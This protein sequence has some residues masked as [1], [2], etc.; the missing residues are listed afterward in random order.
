LLASTVAAVRL[1]PRTPA[2]RALLFTG[3]ALAPALQILPLPRFS[4]PHYAHLAT[5]GAGLLLALAVRRAQ[6][7]GPSVRST[8][9]GLAAAWI[10][11]AGLVTL[12]GGPRFHD[13]V[14]LFGPELAA[15][16]DF[17]E[18][19]MQLGLHFMLKGDH[20]RAAAAFEECLRPRPGL[21][22]FRDDQLILVNLANVR[23]AQG[24]A[25]EAER[26]LAEAARQARPSDAASIAGNRAFLAAQRGDDAA[27]VELLRP[28]VGT[29]TRPEPLMLLARSLGRL[30]RREESMDVLRRVL[31]LVEGEPRRRIEQLVASAETR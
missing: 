13:D 7:V 8:V 25:R 19:H 30:G 12:K 27:V 4:S 11:V 2:G 14:A 5:V 6:A 23:V 9:H 24:R 17:I 31:P 26:L 28:H 21:L 1:G 16:P 15:D 29:T 20:D 22:A 18:G 10:A 3:I